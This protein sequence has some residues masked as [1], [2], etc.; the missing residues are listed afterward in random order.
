MDAKAGQ[1]LL[2]LRST[3]TGIHVAGLRDLRPNQQLLATNAL[4]LFRVT[5][6]HERTK[7]EI[8]LTAE[9]GWNDFNVP[10][11]RNGLELRWEKPQNENLQGITVTATARA[12]QDNSAF[13]WRLRLGSC[14]LPR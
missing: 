6:R 3:R 8:R 2:T 12:D 14:S 13:H 1:L 4:A 11:N 10:Q 9:D 7:G 5:L